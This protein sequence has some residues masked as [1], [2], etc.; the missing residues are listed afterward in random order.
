MR[1]MVYNPRL[2]DG[3]PAVRLDPTRHLFQGYLHWKGDVYWEGY[4]LTYEAALCD[5]EHRLI[6]L[7][8]D[9]SVTC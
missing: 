9:I 3:I 8:G 5:A 7:Q 6:L 4:R 1:S 2:A